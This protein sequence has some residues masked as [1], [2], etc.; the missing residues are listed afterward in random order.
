MDS[1]E[2]DNVKAEKAEAIRRFNRNQNLKNLVVLL[3]EVLL[4]FFSISWLSNK[5]PDGLQIAG[6]L[7][8]EVSLVLDRQLSCFVLVNFLVL[9]IFVLSIWKS[10]SPEIYEEYAGSSR[11]AAA[12]GN[13][14]EEKLAEDS[15]EEAVVEKQI[16]VADNAVL[17]KRTVE[18]TVT[19]TEE[20]ESERAV[21]SVEQDALSTVTETDG[22]FCGATFAVKEVERKGYR[23]SRSEIPDNFGRKTRMELRRSESA[24]TGGEMVIARTESPRK[25][26][27]DLSNEEF[28]LTIERFIAEKKKTLI[29]ENRES[30]NGDHEI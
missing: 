20:S 1:V 26:V 10:K 15:A 5:T 23:R 16:I 3:S 9:V 18:E 6:D 12:A 21:F 25:S 11:S 30:L 7:F 8:R 28:R 13:K 29:Q 19:V 14:T 17:E 24:T 2:I 22:A 4:A 27:E